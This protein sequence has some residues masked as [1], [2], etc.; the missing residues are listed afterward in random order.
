MGNP[1]LQTRSQSLGKQCLYVLR[2]DLHARDEQPQQAL[3]DA[4]VDLEPYD[5]AAA[6]LPQLLLDHL[7]VVAAALVVEVELGVARH[8]VRAVARSRDRQTL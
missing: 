6:A 2:A 7:Q 1:S 5:P 4:A 8:A 3:A